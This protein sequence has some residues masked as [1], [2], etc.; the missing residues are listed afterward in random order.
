MALDNDLT[1]AI[2]DETT[3]AF[4]DEVRA[5]MRWQN[6]PLVQMI[7]EVVRATNL[8]TGAGARVADNVATRNVVGAAEDLTQIHNDIMAGRRD[9][10]GYPT[11]G[12]SE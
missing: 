11:D 12:G 5:R 10:L 3:A 7:E 1:N 6:S 4:D 2:L 8:H 9:G